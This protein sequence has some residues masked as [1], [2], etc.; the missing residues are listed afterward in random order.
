[1]P[2]K[3][4]VG[5]SNFVVAKRVIVGNIR[6]NIRIMFYVKNDLKSRLVIFIKLFLYKKVCSLVIML[7]TKSIIIKFQ[8]KD[9]F[10]G[11]FE[12]G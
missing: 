11:L 4:R 8:G 1:M 9:H 12:D 10:Y 3:V 2:N 5:W 7:P 6:G